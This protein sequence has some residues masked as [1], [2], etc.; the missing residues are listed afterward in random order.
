MRRKT[1]LDEATRS[2]LAIDWVWQI[3]GWRWVAGWL[4]YRRGKRRTGM[5]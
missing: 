2:D 1:T 4:A 3:T 5:W